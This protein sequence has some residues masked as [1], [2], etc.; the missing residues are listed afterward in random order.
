LVGGKHVIPIEATYRQ[1]WY[2]NVRKY[3]GYTMSNL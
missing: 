2:Q 3:I 1:V